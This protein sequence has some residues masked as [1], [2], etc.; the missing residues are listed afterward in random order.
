VLDRLLGWQPSETG[1]RFERWLHLGY[2][3]FGAAFALTVVV[4]AFVH[5]TITLGPGLVEESDGGLA[6]L[7]R[8]VGGLPTGAAFGVLLLCAFVLAWNGILLYR[9]LD[10]AIPRREVIAFFLLNAVF[11]LLLYVSLGLAGVA[12][13]A[14][15]HRFA[16]GLEIVARFTHYSRALVARVPTLVRLPYPLPLIASVFV[17]DLFHYWFHRLGHTRR[18]FWLLWHRP[19]HLTPHLTIPTTQAVFVAFPLFILLSVPFQV[20][21]GVCAK[22]FS[23]E[24]M[25]FEALLVRVVG[26]IVAIGSHNTA[27]YS[28]FFDNR[29]LR[30][31]SL[32]YGEGPYHYIHHS[33]L[34]EHAMVNLGTFFMLWDRIFG[35]YAAPTAT[36]MPVGL[37]GSPRLHL[38]P[39]RLALAGLWQIGY[40]LRW[41][42]GFATRLAIVFG[43]SSFSPPR[44]RDFALDE[45]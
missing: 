14:L 4:D 28:T 22:L 30:R 39:L 35:T 42:R 44:S 29:V 37:T 40:E 23:S 32:V 15:G 21:V 2:A 27:L 24:T 26:Q 45:S 18:A 36:R 34:P 38:N 25:I 5:E 13:A 31:L 8:Q 1:A 33:A 19:H 3:I 16:S 6:Q 41:N 12:S 9:G 17:V 10:D 7:L 20:G 43:S 11:A